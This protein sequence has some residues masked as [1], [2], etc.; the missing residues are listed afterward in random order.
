H[1]IE[2]AG[3]DTVVFSGSDTI[4]PARLRELGWQ[5]EARRIDLI[6]APALTDVAGP[7]LHARPVAGLPLIHV[8]IPTF[9]GRRYIS[10]R[11]FDIIASLAGLVLLSPL[12]LT[13]ALIVRADGGPA[14]FRQERVG[15]NGRRFRML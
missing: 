13:L 6:V 9:E 3:A 11:A 5:L 7:R 15:L 14:L 1:G 8:D 12:L 10:K 4:S 2:R